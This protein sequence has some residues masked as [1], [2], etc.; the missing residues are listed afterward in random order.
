[1]KNS[2]IVLAREWTDLQ[3]RDESYEPISRPY[4][5]SGSSLTREEEKRRG[6]PFASTPLRGRANGKD[7]REQG[8]RQKNMA[9]AFSG[10]WTSHLILAAICRGEI[11]QEGIIPSSPNEEPFLTGIPDRPYM[12]L[13]ARAAARRRP[14]LLQEREQR[15]SREVRERYG[16]G[17]GASP[18]ERP[19]F[20]PFNLPD[21]KFAKLNHGTLYGRSIMGTL[22]R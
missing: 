22:C 7:G 18:T 10:C 14:T 13:R 4:I 11:S 20:G 3:S 9:R 6:Q 16:E 8:K 15:S 17:H 2:S 21:D 19:K 1:M 12:S 5:F